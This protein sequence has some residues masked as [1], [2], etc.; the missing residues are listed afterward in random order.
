M[1]LK[2]KIALLFLFLSLATITEARFEPN[3]LIT[4]V[5]SNGVKSTTCAPC[6]DNCG[7]TK[8][9][10]PQCR[11]TDVKPTCHSA[12]KSCRCFETLPLKCDCLDIT[13]F[14]YEPCTS[15]TIA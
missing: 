7:C 3:S 13:D 12:C 1:E 6:C 11:C 2:M 9:I 15:T 8:S 4:Q 5:L 10:P 14:C